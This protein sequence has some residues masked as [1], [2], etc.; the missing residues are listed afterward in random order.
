MLS[1]SAAASSQTLGM[2]GTPAP[3]PGN[4]SNT[5]QVHV[6]LHFLPGPP[7]DQCSGL[8]VTVL[9]QPH[10]DPLSLCLPVTPVFLTRKLR[11][12][13]VIV[14]DWGSDRLLELLTGGPSC[15]LVGLRLFVLPP[16]VMED[17]ASAP[18]R[19]REDV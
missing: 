3:S 10:S 11:L 14:T 6:H 13:R 4:C 12:T 8:Y 9:G 1:T 17:L 16:D 2:L 15:F 5:S 19:H 7:S 18:A